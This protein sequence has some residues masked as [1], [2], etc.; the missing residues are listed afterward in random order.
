MIQLSNLTKRFGPFT[1]VGDLSFDIARGETFALLGPNG[2]GKTT[3]LKCIVGL[4]HPTSGRIVVDGIDI[5]R[6]GRNARRLMSYLPQRVSFQESLTAREVMEFY[7]R[8]RK[9]PRARVDDLMERSSF[10]FNG[11][12]DKPVSEFSGGMIQRLGLAVACLADAPIMVLDEPTISLDPAGAIEFREFL[13]SLKRQ[14]KTFLF[15]SHMLTDV[16]QLADR[17]AILVG[18]KLVALESVAALREGLMRNS[19][20]RVV[21]RNP[22]ARWIEVAREAGAEAAALDGDSL[23]ITCRAE[24]RLRILRA[25]EAAGGAVRSFA[26]E[27]LSLEDVYLKYINEGADR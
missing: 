5:R 2:S 6:D 16:E 1:A 14:G 22:D 21:L 10:H 12:T 13:A 15:S 19:K 23:L 25:I 17:V 3:T 8:L 24:D 4:T 7:C 9:L 11:F 20:M 27:E 18:G 26:T